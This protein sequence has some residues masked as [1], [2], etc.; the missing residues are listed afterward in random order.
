MG[1]CM[2][3][4]TNP[5]LGTRWGWV[6]SFTPAAIPRKEEPTVSI[7]QEVGLVLGP[8]CTFWRTEQ[9][10]SLPGI[11]PWFVGH[12]ARS[13]AGILTELSQL[14]STMAMKEVT[15]ILCIL[16]RMQSVTSKDGVTACNSQK[17][18]LIM[19]HVP[20]WPN[21]ERKNSLITSPTD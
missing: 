20:N 21:L 19:L 5:D 13:L 1:N 17:I 18:L 14:P 8:I 7:L 4:S 12:P 16:A 15:K 10:L 2:N 6:A 11:Y 9:L 3:S